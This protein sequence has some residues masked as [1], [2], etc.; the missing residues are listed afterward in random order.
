MVHKRNHIK[1]GFKMKKILVICLV[2]FLAAATGVYAKDFPKRD[3]TNVVVWG[4]GG[5]T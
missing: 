4:A 2:V 1:G 5:G 3:I